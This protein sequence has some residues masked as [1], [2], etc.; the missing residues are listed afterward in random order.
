M[1]DEFAG[2]HPLVN[3]I[4]FLLVLGFG[5]F[6]MHPVCLMVSLIG[7]LCYCALINGTRK[8]LKN[9]GI[10]L[11][12]MLFVGALNAAFNHAGVTPLMYL[13][14]GNAI[15]LESLVYGAASGVMLVSVL[16]W[17]SC[18]NAV[19][20]TDKLIFLF[21][22]A[23]PSLSIL[24]SMTLRFIPR[25]RTQLT[26]IR[27]AR[28]GMNGGERSRLREAVQ[29]TSAMLGWSMENAIETA[30]SMKCR[31]HGLPGRT[32]YSNYRMDSRDRAMLVWLG[33]CAVYLISGAAA[34]G[35]YWRYYPGFTDG[36]LTPMRLSFMAVHLAL[37]LTPVLIDLWEDRK[38]KLLRS[39]I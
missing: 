19:M 23:A 31:G 33:F 4:F 7:A 11:P 22:R 20:S 37:A 27:Q 30:D 24:L 16:C 13:P 29:L 34:G 12:M 26:R 15:T 39:E 9:L 21:G 1:R 10:A 36:E 14:N 3:L 17:F 35:F 8:M 28:R 5:M 32:S 38:W 2:F 6:A 18:F 25:F